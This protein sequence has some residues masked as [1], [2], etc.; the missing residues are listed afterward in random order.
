MDPLLHL[1]RNAVSH[2]LET[3]R[4]RRDQNKPGEGRLTLRAATFGESILLEIAD[5]GSGIDV[6]KVTA[7]AKAKQLISS[8]ASLDNSTLLD[9]LCAPGFSTR[10]KADRESGRGI[11]M[12]VVRNTVAALGGTLALE[13]E[14]NRGTRFIIELPLTLA[15]AEAL[16]AMV[17]DQKFAVPQSAV[18]E[19]IEVERSSVKILENNEIISYR[20]GVLPLLRLSRLFELGEDE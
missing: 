7:R 17:G 10:D 16:I 2:G 6:E 1:V 9:V 4:A 14:K 18:R 5:D 3:P 19:V 11:G 13:T 12:D 15:I 20:G 8:E